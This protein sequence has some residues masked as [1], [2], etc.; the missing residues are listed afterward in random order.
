MKTFTLNGK[1]KFTFC[2]L[3]ISYL[4]HSQSIT[5]TSDDSFVPP[6]GLTTVTVEAWGAGGKGGTRTNTYVTGGGGGGAYAKKT[7][8]LLNPTSNT[9]TVGMGS[10]SNSSPGGDSWFGSTGTVLAKGG[11]S[12]AQN[13]TIGAT[14][15]SATLSVGDAGFKFSGGNGATGTPNTT[16]GNSGGGGSSAGTA[17]NGANSNS[18]N[19]AT[20]PAGGGNGG[21]GASNSNSP[22]NDGIFPGGGGGGALRRSGGSKNGGDGA[23]GQIIVSYTCP[24]Y[25]LTSPASN[26]GPICG[27]S[28]AV[29]TLRSTSMLAGTYTVTYNLSGATNAGGMTATMVF[30]SGTP[31]NGTFTTSNLNNGVTNIT[32][33][34]ISS[35]GSVT[36]G[37]AVAT[38]NTTTV[39]I[40][41]PP[42]ANAGTAINTCVTTPSVSISTGASASNYTAVQWTTSGT[43][44]FT[45][46]TNVAGCIYT[47]S[48]ADKAAGSVILTLTATGNAPCNNI[49]SNKTLTINRLPVANAGN[50]IATCPTAP[51]VNVTD[52]AT[53]SFY[54]SV[55][56]SSTGTGTF[57]NANSMTLATYTPS[58]ADK[59]AG[60]VTLRLTVYGISPC[61]STMATKLL[62]FNPNPTAVAGTAITACASDTAINITAGS[63]ATNHTAVLWSSSGTG[64]FTD[65][66]SLTTCTYYPS[67]ADI[68]AGGV[69]I[70]LS[71]LSPNCTNGTATKMLTLVPS[72][73]AN[74]GTNVNTCYN[75]GTILITAGASASNYT[76]VAWSSSGTGTF[77]DAD[78]MTIAAYTPSATD[79]AAGS[80]TLIL[81]ATANEPCNSSATATKTLFINMTPTG[82]AG[83]ALTTCNSSGPINVTAGATA[84]D[85]TSLL[86][87][88]SGTGTFTNA[89]SL[90]LATYSPSAADIS[91][92]GV[93]LTLTITSA[94]CG[95]DTSTK[96]L[97][98]YNTPSITS[99]TPATRTGAGTVI[100]GATTSSG[101]IYWYAAASG[102]T[103]LGFGSSFTTPVISA[104]TTYYVE[105]MNGTCPSAPRTAVVATVIYPEIDIRGNATSITDGDTTPSTGD[106]TDFGSTTSTRT[107]T[108]NNSGV[109]GLSLA[110]PVLSG[111]NAGDFTISVIPNATVASNATTTFTVTFN[112]TAPGIR[113]ATVT[114]SNNDSNENPY[115][116]A[117]QGTGVAREI[118]VQGNAVV[119]ADNDTTPALT[120]WTD[121]SSVAGT[122]TYT[123][124]NLGNIVMTLGAITIDGVNATDFVVTTPPAAT[125][126]AYAST[127]FTVTFTP[128]AILDRY[129]AIHIANND[130]DE[131]P[132][133]FSIHGYGVIPEIEIR[134][135]ATII[136]ENDNTPST[137]DWTDFGSTTVTRTFTINNLGNTVLTLGAMTW[138]GTN[139]TEFSVTTPPSSSVAAFSSTTFVVTFSPSTT[140]T[141]SAQLRI[142]NNDSNESPYRFTVQ[143]TGVAQEIDIQGNATTITDGD[144]TPSTADWTD[145]S[146]VALS[147]TFTI[148]N[149]GNLPLTLGT[150]SFSG[151]NPT[152][153]AVTTAPVSPVPAFGSTTFTVTFTQGSIGTRSANLSIVNNDSN[154][155]PYDFALKA[156]G[157]T[158]EINIKSQFDVN[159]A[160][161]DN[162]PS[163]SDQTNFGEVSMDGG[164]VTVN[165]VMENTGS[166]AMSVGAATFTG[167]NASNFTLTTPPAA[168]IAAGSSSKFQISFSPT[169]T[170]PKSATFS[171][172]NNDGNENPYNFDLSGMGV[173]TYKDTDADGVT[174]NKDLDDDNDGII[175]TKEQTDGITY[176]LT[177]LVEYVFLNETFG[178][179]TT[180]GQIN[181]NTPGAT[182]TYCYD[183]GYGSACEATSDLQD[184]EYTVNHMISV[185][186]SASDPRNLAS[187]AS[188]HWTAQ[189]D[190]TGNT[191]GRMAIFNASY[192]PGTFYEIRIDGVIPNVPINYSFWVLNII[193]QERS[194]IGILPNIT[195]EFIDTSNNLISSYTTGDI[196]RCGSDTADDS[197]ALSQWKQFTTN[198]NL[199]NVTSFI[200]RFK[201]NSTG[202]GGND[203]AID[204]IKITQ[205]YI[206]TDGDGIANIFD[207]DD[208]NDGISDVE[209]AGFKQYSNGLSKMDLSGAATWID[210]NGNGLHDAIDAQISGGTYLIT[211]TDAD[212]VPNYLDLDSDNDSLFDVDEA[213]LFNGDGDING[214]GKG[215]LADTDRD[216][217]LDLYDNNTG[218]GTA[219]RSYAQDTDGNSIADYLQLDSDNDGVKDIQAGLYATLDANNDGSI[220][221]SADID[222]DGILDS[223]DT[224][225][226]VIGSPR[227][228]NR[229]LYL[230]F[231]GR[232]DYGQGT[233][234]LGGRTTVSMMAWIDLAAGYN[235]DGVV[236][237]Q[238]NFFLRINSARQ[239]Q[240]VVNGTPLTYGTPLAV[241]QWHHV[242][243]TLTNGFL[244]LYLN[245]NMVI[246]DNIGTGISG[247]TNPLTIGR[248]SSTSA[249]Y[250][251]GKIDEVR[252][253]SVALTDAQFQ[254]MVYQE[255]QNSGSV[256]RG[257]IVPKNVP[258]ALW[259][260]V[261]RYYRMDA[262]K[263]DI[264]D[265]LT[266]A[267]IDFGTG[268]KI[269]NNKYI[270]VQQA[271]MPFITERTGDF[272]TAVNNLARDIRGMDVMDQDWSIVQVKHNITQ[273]ANNVDL[274]MF[275]D[276]GVTIVANN[277]IKI[278]NDWYLLLDGKIDLQG[279]SQLLQTIDS[280][281][282]LSSGGSIER[283]QQGQASIFNYNYW[284]SPVG[285]ISTTTNNNNFTVNG[286][287]RDGTNPN[288]LQNIN[289]VAGYNG[290]PTSPIS[291]SNYWI[292]KFQNT[293]PVYANWTSVGPN[294]AL[295]AGQGYTMKGSG[296]A[297]PTQ[298]LAFQGKPHNGTITIPIAANNLNLS[299]NP[300]ASALD[301]DQ[302]LMNNLS[303]TTGAV[304][305]WEHYSTNTTHVLQN[306]QAGYATRNLTGGTPPVAPAGI[307]GVGTSSRIPGRFIPVGQGFFI[308]GNATGG[309]IIFNN[310]Q[311]LFV[312]EDN[313]N[314]NFMFKQPNNDGPRT[315]NAL[316]TNEED[317]FE[318]DTFTR[319]RLGYTSPD[320]YHRQVLLG[321]MNE[322]ATAGVDPGY[323]APHLD[324]QPS[325]M[326]FINGQT[327]LNIQGDGYFNTNNQYPIGVKAAT[328]GTIKLMLDD[329]ENFDESQEVYILDNLTSTYHSI[330]ETSFDIAVPAGETNDRFVLT[331]KTDSSLHTDNFEAN[332]AVQAIYTNDD[333]MIT[334][335]NNALD[336]TV[337]T[338]MLFNM[339]GQSITTWD[340]ANLPQNKIQLPVKNLS[341]GTYI[342][343]VLTSKGE[344]SK[345]V[346]IK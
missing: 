143:G 319:V 130:A 270:K 57:T 55:L 156:T 276:P 174:D 314:S 38:N 261:L 123:I 304:Y 106:W 152:D 193:S 145:F 98:I 331:F 247:D 199:G 120:D 117:I 287:M 168:T 188:A 74:A 93:I 29:V 67:A 308:N 298:N 119:I 332:T 9:I 214:D 167:A 134:G 307:S 6:A 39:T 37:N 94:G 206:D 160:D 91:A 254:K 185:P 221:G 300:Y 227:D 31:N 147:R 140:G 86:W 290:A 345:K 263:D 337:K 262:Y 110:V 231:D 43:G 125:L 305:F 32:I 175:D 73:A 21:S 12:V 257:A 334:V 170:G 75:S 184:G 96:T 131:N 101:T 121:F 323:D 226:S 255:I 311:R 153:F 249:Q 166:G 237:G 52:G 258:G 223:F 142:V 240:V 10:I 171:I 335:T 200:V 50:P 128:G 138:A 69:T 112:P 198:A 180:K 99:T 244:K 24:T 216:G 281:L 139:P 127:T 271:P 157:G 205:N 92:G 53:A 284:S 16:S 124:R 313:A 215:D 218:F 336:T 338:V 23:N 62:T 103:A 81:T 87:T 234:L 251:K 324:N 78:S 301:S 89:N 46:G 299:G 238:D 207:L 63:S 211:D 309:N 49:A 208:E 303:S 225:T 135:N 144:A 192:A 82:D 194:T 47:P 285:A 190:H 22:G 76:S 209:E 252:V 85:Y 232:N 260:S 66:N 19:G 70:T 202:G 340:V 321:F 18:S 88:S 5:Y 246:T 191:N 118:E 15:G 235:A 217:I 105:A 148:R 68:A 318:P 58:A 30:I 236:L 177:S 293:S 59:L 178:A 176:P 250:F 151:T 100:L 41:A 56:W 102:G 296:A 113:T 230:D 201:N 2:L 292:Y 274:A 245:G 189:T 107:F 320:N 48:A 109:G 72:P 322:R 137:T 149:T 79:I 204:D 122:R 342:V 133:D 242:G 267:S 20:A 4:S 17:A 329:T 162:T 222:K 35:T 132:F 273:T 339:I 278:Q 210:V 104:T 280:D 116:F 212:G 154:E 172:V 265:D 61:A 346:I 36:C 159:I 181:I 108:I 219:P 326:Y 173:Q 297:T 333:H 248:M 315:T 164:I 8:V 3:F 239:L 195:V 266:T 325:D 277:D 196:G 213:G 95:S 141:R 90:T 80:V 220:D 114:I 312:K 264:I 327:K 283:D 84:A 253:F 316:F 302:F 328:A 14:G 294:G 60:S 187:W 1:I 51:A 182:C 330:R 343:K 256:V 310:G 243:A 45:N 203:L 233:T 64:T 259:S 269:F 83:T 25:L 288:N 158:P 146:S 279:K 126:G 7:N 27:S 317:A 71:A 169:T 33:T 282:A 291:I 163:S 161:G 11:S 229:K 40:V 97:T 289:F 42:T 272:A 224:N 111:A 275:V 129:A 241:S 150:F 344:L 54:S 228:L 186:G 295:F 28:A 341:T 44:T 179:G 26:N 136:A 306:Y 165:F 115:D 65:A 155:N 13:A 183:D 34:Y 77:I 268:M 286:V 197:C